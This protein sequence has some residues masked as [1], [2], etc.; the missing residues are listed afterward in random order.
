MGLIEKFRKKEKTKEVQ[1]EVIEH[2]ADFL[3]TKRNFGAYPKDYGIDSYIYIGSGNQTVLKIIADIKRGLEKY[4]KRIQDIEIAHIPT[5]NSLQF[6]FLITCKIQA[7]AL[8]FQ[9]SF[10]HQ[11]N[12]YKTETDL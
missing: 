5:D 7:D 3:N 2:L 8:S 1:E 4:E 6:S 9:L 11:K 12:F 10:H